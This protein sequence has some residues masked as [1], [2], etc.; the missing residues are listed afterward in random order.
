MWL[1][2]LLLAVAAALFFASRGGL[3]ASSPREPGDDAPTA[4]RGVSGRSRGEDASATAKA[5]RHRP[6]A[7]PG[8][9]P[10]RP[11]DGAQGERARSDVQERRLSR[12]QIYDDAVLANRYP[13]DSKPLTAEMKDILKPYSRYERPLPVLR[14]TGTNDPET[15]PYFLFSASKYTLF[16]GDRFDP[17]LEVWKGQP[18]EDGTAERQPVEIKECRIQK[19]GNRKLELLGTVPLN[20]RG[21]LGDRANDG[22]YSVDVDPKTVAA[23]RTGGA[24]IQLEVDFQVPGIDGV[25]HAVLQF[26]LGLAEPARFDGHVDE[27]LKPTGLWLSV[28]LDVEEAGRYV[29]QGLVFDAKGKPIGY[30]VH[31]EDFQKG[32]HKAPLQFFGL[33]FHEAAAPGPYVLKTV[34]GYR[35]PNGDEPHRAD[36]APMSGEYRTKAYKLPDFSDKEWESDEKEAHLKALSDFVEDDREKT[37]EVPR[38]RP[39]SAPPAASAP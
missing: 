2:A 1:G 15:S 5:E 6:P 26:Q 3:R 36:M 21:E 23:L 39:S 24:M 12:Q 11:V 30:A 33:L 38:S 19:L 27:Q 29:V 7:A 16:P 25:T 13:P 10:G 22:V 28:G 20:D 14:K 31:R 4:T 18:K 34:T 9:I 32:S 37:L 8:D 17:K 35:L